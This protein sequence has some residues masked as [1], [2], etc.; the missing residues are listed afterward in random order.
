MVTQSSVNNVLVIEAP[1][2]MDKYSYRRSAYDKS[3][4]PIRIGTSS[5]THQSPSSNNRQTTYTTKTTVSPSSTLNGGPRTTTESHKTESKSS[6]S[7]TTHTKV[8][9]SSSGSNLLNDEYVKTSS[10]YQQPQP[11]SRVNFTTSQSNLNQSMAPELMTGYPMYDNDERCVVYKFD[12]SG[13]DNSEIHLTITADRVLEI[14]ACKE[15]Y[16]QLGKIY[17]EFKREIH[18]EPEVD[19]KLIKNILHD[20]ILTLKIPKAT[21]PDGLGSASNTHNINAPN[22]FK[23]IYTDDGKLSKLTGDFRGFNPENVK[24]V[25]SANNVIKVTAQ[26]SESSPQKGS[27]QKECTRHYTLP[28]WIQPEN[29]KAIMSRDGILTID[30]NSKASPSSAGGDRINIS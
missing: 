6:S 12:L 22:G 8:V 1:I 10:S 23:E 26:Q 21:R 15:T 25:L 28:A 11:I 17:R 7:S 3:Q 2:I 18:L 30:F 9:R 24:I 14:K 20:G 19:D 13:F 5:N 16:D 29:M 27:I 4:S